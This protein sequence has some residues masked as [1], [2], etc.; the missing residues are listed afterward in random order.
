[1]HTRNINIK[2]WNYYFLAFH[3]ENSDKD[4]ESYCLY[5]KSVNKQTSLLGTVFNNFSPDLKQFPNSLDYKIR[6]G[7]KEFESNFNNELKYR[8]NGPHTETSKY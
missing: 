8:V 2:S 6:Y 3:S 1:M 4:L 5:K 7:F